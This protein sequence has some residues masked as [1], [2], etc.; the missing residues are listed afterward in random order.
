MLDKQRSAGKQGIN[1]AGMHP[2][3]L[4]CSSTIISVTIFS[5][6]VLAIV[7]LQEIYGG[8]RVFDIGSSTKMLL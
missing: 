1:D 2:S 6:T 4:I 8:G 7:I 5:V 3:Q